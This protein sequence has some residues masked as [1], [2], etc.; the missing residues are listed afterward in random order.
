MADFYPCVTCLVLQS[1]KQ[2]TIMLKKG[3]KNFEFT[4]THPRYYLE[5]DRPSQTD[6]YKFI[7]IKGSVTFI[8][9]KS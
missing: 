9:L 3:K 1:S 7:T 4:H 6:T 5:G 8:I 2:F